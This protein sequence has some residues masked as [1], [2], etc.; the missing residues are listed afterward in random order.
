MPNTSISKFN[1]QEIPRMTLRDMLGPLFRHSTVVAV[2]FAF[3]FGVSVVVALVWA[4]HYYVA[5]MQVV[6]SRERLDPTLTPQ[7]TTVVQETD[8]NV[9]TDDVASEITI[10]QGQDMLRDVVQTCGMVHTR[11]SLWDKFDSRPPELKKAAAI[12]AETRSVAGRLKVE[13]QKSSHVIELRYASTAPPESS[14]CVLQTLGKLYLEKHLRLQRP[15]GA[16][17]FFS[18]ETDKYQKALKR[19]EAELVNF[20]KIGGLAVPDL[21]RSNLAQQLAAAHANLYNSRQAV[22]ADQQRIE[23]IKAQMAVTP[24]RS[25]TIEASISANLLL[26]QLKS[27]LLA[28][29]LKRTQLLL[30]Y[31]PS[32]P[33]VQ[34]VDTEIAQTEEAIAHGEQSRYVNKT[35]DRDPTYEYLRQDMAKTEAD[36]ASEQARATVL[37]ASIH[38]I[39]LKMV[40]LDVKSVEQGALLREAKANEGNYLLYLTKREQERTSDALDARRIANVAI[41]VPATVPTL[42]AHSSSSVIFAGFWLALLVAIA[43]GYLA[44]L[45]DPS[46]RTPAEV[47]RLLHIPILAAVPRQVA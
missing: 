27:T 15:V 21:V 26:D 18:Q 19:S 5:T 36:L 13:A 38:D 1:Q 4:R 28:A 17:D 35:T 22:A 46:L 20:S 37:S 3:V 6:L 43:A 7:P 24:N 16:L 11:P 41:A 40:D 29:Q 30:K 33:L 25:N 47:E 14:A 31:D 39:Q 10:L 2:T 8:K 45:A 12:E 23:N 32:Y 42:P 44:E 9:S 34:E